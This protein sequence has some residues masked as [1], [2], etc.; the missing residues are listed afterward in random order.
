VS[1]DSEVPAYVSPDWLNDLNHQVASAADRWGLRVG[2]R[3]GTGN[4]SR[5][6]ACED[7]VHRPVVLKLAP[8]EMRPDL[9]AAALDLWRGEGAVRL[10]DY[11]PDLRALLLERLVPGTPPPSGQDEE[12]VAQIAATL[13]AVQSAPVPAEH[14]LPSLD[15]F[16]DT[17]VQWN[18]G[19]I[20]EGAAGADL[21][22]TACE[23]GKRLARTATASVVLHGDFIDKNLL[24]S[25]RG[26]V[27]IDPIPRVGDPCS[28]VGFYASYHPP[29]GRTAARGRGF[30]RALGLEPECCA[31]WAAVW[32]VGEAC[33]TWR[34]DSDELQAWINGPEAAEL[35]EL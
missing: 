18:R 31:R 35:L 20:D 8:P 21:L 7:S 32:A 4:T 27:A 2:D 13:V 12:S 29:A 14:D 24:L 9:E 33:E 19:W 10:L 1:P 23:V 34:A 25:D 5:V 28:D 11:A 3:L 16:L 26:Y 30:A 15:A 22:D 6:F 17:W